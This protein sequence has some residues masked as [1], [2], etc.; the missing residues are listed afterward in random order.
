MRL[1]LKS[2]NKLNENEK[3]Y[4]AIP[5]TAKTL[6][7]VFIKLT[8]TSETYRFINTI[9]NSGEHRDILD[10]K[11]RKDR[12]N[13][14][15]NRDDYTKGVDISLLLDAMEFINPSEKYISSHRPFSEEEAGMAKLTVKIT[16]HDTEV[17]GHEGRKRAL[18]RWM[19]GQNEIPILFSQAQGGKQLTQ[20]NDLHLTIV[21]EHGL[22][23]SR[24]E[25][26]EIPGT[27][28]NDKYIY[29]EFHDNSK[30]EDYNPKIHNIFDVYPSRTLLTKERLKK[31]PKGTIYDNRIF[32]KAKPDKN[33]TEY[34]KNKDEL[35]NNFDV[36]EHPVS[37]LGINAAR[38]ERFKYLIS[39][40]PQKF[41]DPY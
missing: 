16:E 32:Y 30:D 5:I 25:F 26:D 9:I 13:E 33:V 10:L 17:I 3:I 38:G 15:I 39:K 21:G 27:Q 12:I 4:T 31:F 36:V 40:I 22:E 8:V 14:L 11:S 18:V 37:E 23:V 24:S 19:L 29:L 7:S 34:P 2:K 6:P 41:N 20:L 35:E 1:V 28:L